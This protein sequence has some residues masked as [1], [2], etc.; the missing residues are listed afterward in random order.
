[1]NL[2]HYWINLSRSIKR[3]VFMENQFN[4]R[5]IKNYRVSAITP[6]DFDILL[7][8]KRPLTCKHPGCINCEY[9]FACI[10]SHIKAMKA[11]LDDDNNKNNEW[12][13]IMEDDMF[14]P[15]N[16]NYDELIKDAPKDFDIIQ[17]C[18]SYGNTV[19]ILYNELFI[20]NKEN[21]I[22]WRY[23]LPC[24]GMYII[25][26]KGAEKLVNKFYI[27]GKYDFSSCEYQIVADVALYSTVNTYA[28]TFPCAYPN[29][30]MGS[31]IHPH[32][33]DAHNS[34]IIDIKKVLNHAI[35]N[36]SIKYLSKI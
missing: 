18:I 23:L 10:S 4:N 30:E 5:N 6:D 12:F 36:N 3:R 29:I 17:L 14:I 26:R 20:K 21:F 9:E 8:N 16:I 32:H 13:V 15:Y 31:E 22:K 1:M 7:E 35:S 34:A 11:G 25:S 33:L 27:N 19:K 28:T 24:A 2:V